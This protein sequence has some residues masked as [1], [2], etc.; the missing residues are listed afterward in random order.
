ME[1]TSTVVVPTMVMPAMVMPTVMVPTMA[2]LSVAVPTTVSAH[3][4]NSIGI[5]N[6]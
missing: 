5:T 4:G 2:T 6:D 3:S 1:M